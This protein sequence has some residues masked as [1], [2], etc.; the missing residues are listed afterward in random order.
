MYDARD[1]PPVEG[2]MTEYSWWILA[3]ATAIAYWRYIEIPGNREKLEARA[4]II[5]ERRAE[6]ERIRA[7]AAGAEA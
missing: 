4:A 1:T 2:G 6:R 3:R 5:R 7:A